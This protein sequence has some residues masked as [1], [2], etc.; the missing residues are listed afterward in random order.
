LVKEEIKK[1]IKDFLDL[2][3]N[4]CTIYSNLWDTMKVVLGGKLIALFAIKKKLEIICPSTGECQEQ[5]DGVGG[6]GSR[7]GEGI[8]DFG[9]I[10]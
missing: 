3:E 6:L 5:E 7:V 1:E 4:E 8:G 2:N 9:D 10:I